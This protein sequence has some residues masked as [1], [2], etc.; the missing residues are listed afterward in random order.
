MND[1]KD[2]QPIGVSPNIDFKE[3]RTPLVFH[4]EVYAPRQIYIWSAGKPEETSLIFSLTDGVLSETDRQ[5]LTNHPEP[6]KIYNIPEQKVLVPESRNWTLTEEQ[7]GLLNYATTIDHIFTEGGFAVARAWEETEESDIHGDAREVYSFLSKAHLRWL[8]VPEDDIVWLGDIGEE[9]ADISQRL[10]QLRIEED[11]LTLKGG[12][13]PAEIRAL[14]HGTYVPAMPQ[15]LVQ[16]RQDRQ[17]DFEREEIS[18]QLLARLS[19]DP[20]KLQDVKA[21]F[22]AAYQ[23]V[24]LLHKKYPVKGYVVT[25]S[26]IH[27]EKLRMGKITRR[28]TSFVDLKENFPSDIDMVICIEGDGKVAQKVADRMGRDLMLELGFYP[29]AQVY[30]IAG[31]ENT[32]KNLG[33]NEWFASA[34]ELLDKVFNPQV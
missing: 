12:P 33:K 21:R 31:L 5:E 11:K 20:D 13:V 22:A 29:H 8:G 3:V 19:E 6:Y 34:K 27:P 18:P 23:F 30:D 10:A 15:G 2:T 4:R 16:E 32:V 24:K 14:I 17:S 28:P 25:G 9:T 26:S 7:R 1:F